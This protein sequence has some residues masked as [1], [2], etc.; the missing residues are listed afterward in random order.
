MSDGLNVIPS[1]EAEALKRECQILQ[2]ELAK[3]CAEKDHLLHTVAP[4]IEAVYA[5]KIGPKEYEAFQLEVE[6]RTLKRTIEMIQAIENRGEKPNPEQIEAAVEE[7]LRDWH[8]KMKQMLENIQASESQ[9]Q[10][11]MTDEDSEEFQKRY[12]SLVKKLHPDIN[13]DLSEQQINLWHRVQLAY[14]LGNLD[15]LRALSLLVEDIP[16][17]HSP[18]SLEILRERRDA[19][20][21]KVRKYIEYIE[22]IQKGHPFDW[23]EKLDDPEWI[24]SH[25]QQCQLRIDQFSNEKSE[26]EAW[27]VSWKNK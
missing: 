5:T 25:L 4:N 1:P 10:S 26:L 8:L 2:E 6:V 3:L 19:L 13:P 14:Q 24:A 12:R 22:N 11:Q 16:D 20:K 23:L 9:L 18:S 21:S 7:E 27:L 17:D 15:E